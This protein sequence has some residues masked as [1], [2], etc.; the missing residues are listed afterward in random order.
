MTLDWADL[1]GLTGSTLVV[2][3]FAYSNMAN[4][5]NFVLFNAMNLLGA[6]FLAVSLTVHF[7]LS[8]MAL[9]AVWGAVALFGLGKALWKKDKI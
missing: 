4:R 5:I 8:S 9:E 3:A 7:N 2:T 6:I 1:V